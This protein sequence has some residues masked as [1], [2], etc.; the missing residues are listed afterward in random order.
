[1]LF[2]FF[3]AL[4]L[5]F[6]VSLTVMSRP[7]QARP[8]N[9]CTAVVIS[10]PVFYS[11]FKMAATKKFAVPSVDDL[12]DERQVAR[13]KPLFNKYKP[14]SENI[15]ETA[16][17]S[18]TRTGNARDTDKRAEN[19]IATK[20]L[21][22]KETQ[23]SKVY[24]DLGQKTVKEDYVSNQDSS[25]KEVLHPPENIFTAASSSSGTIKPAVGKTFRETFAFLEDTSHYKETVAKIKE[26][27]YVQFKFNIM[28]HQSVLANSHFLKEINLLEN[29]PW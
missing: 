7:S 18:S 28:M 16:D 4:R 6:G 3:F 23:S 22:R 12:D 9:V 2:Q 11:A 1:M 15:Q 21:D 10:A 26:K 14:S 19:H 5:I 25:S 20:T 24:K 27:E 29:T 8:H 17:D 13:P